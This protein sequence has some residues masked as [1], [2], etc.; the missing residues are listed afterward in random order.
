MWGR[1]CGGLD[2]EKGGEVGIK[3][4]QRMKAREEMR[5]F[6][7]F[8][9]CNR[10]LNR[11]RHPTRI[12]YRPHLL[13]VALETLPSAGFLFSNT[14]AQFPLTRPR[15]ARTLTSPTPLDSRLCLLPSHMLRTRLIS[16]APTLRI[17]Q[18]EIVRNNC[19]FIMFMGMG[20]YNVGI[21]LI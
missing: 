13:D 10:S 20:M 11:Q 8:L 14:P 9:L 3:E 17:A 1:R 19:V 12:N 5:C 15:R 2:G 16:I 21:Q 6:N 4:R 7:P 18:P